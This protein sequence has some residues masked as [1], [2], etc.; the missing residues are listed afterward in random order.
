MHRLFRPVHSNATTLVVE[1]HRA[2]LVR[3]NELLNELTELEA[4]ISQAEQTARALG[5]TLG[6]V[7]IHLMDG[8]A[9]RD[10]DAA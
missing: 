5:G 1:S 9:S 6:T 2:M 8:T 4:S 3:R 7:E 10:A